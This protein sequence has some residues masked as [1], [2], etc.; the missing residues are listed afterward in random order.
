[1]QFLENQTNHCDITSMQANDRSTRAVVDHAA[2]RHN[3][4]VVRLYAGRSAKIMAVVKANGYG[5]GMIEMARSAVDWGVEYLGV[6]RVHE[7]NE[8]RQA[9]IRHPIL[10]FESAPASTIEL[11]VASNLDVTVVGQESVEFI[12]GVAQRIGIRARVHVK[13]DTGMGRLGARD[14][15]AIKTVCAT[16]RSRN[17]ELIGVYSH[18][19]TSEDPDESFARQQLDKFLDICDRVRQQGV[20]IPFRHIANSGA[21]ISKPDSIL[22]MVR[23]GIMLYG[24]PPS[25]DMP[26]CHRL[27]P[28]MSL[29]SRIAF[30]KRV[31][32]GVSISYGRRFCTARET[33]IATVPAGY[34]DGYSRSLTN[35]GEALIRGK[36]YPVVGTVCMDQLMLDLGNDTHIRVGDEVTLMGLSGSEAITGWDIAEKTGTIPYEITCQ[37]SPRVLRIHQ[38]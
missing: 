29:L 21:I 2:F 38:P 11:A 7:G 30:L 13:V 8:L 24:Y 15:E 14:G 17:L 10:V 1:M 32:A 23:P 36:R 18:F 33:T 19:A 3:L 22:D 9:N 26:Q 6:A 4:D 20:E 27:R 37:I 35:K 16:A 5:H 25:K 28:V 34:A 31:E 12:S